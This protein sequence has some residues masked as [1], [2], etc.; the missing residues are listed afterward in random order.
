[1]IK[2]IAVLLVF[3]ITVFEAS[4]H[5]NHAV[6]DGLVLY[7]DSPSGALELDQNSKNKLK[8]KRES[9]NNLSVAP[10]TDLRRLELGL[11]GVSTTKGS[12]KAET[13]SNGQVFAIV[14]DADRGTYAILLPEI[15]AYASHDGFAGH[16]ATP[17]G[18][19]TYYNLPNR[20]VVGAD[21]I[22]IRKATD[23]GDVLL[24]KLE[25]GPD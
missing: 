20:A 12:H 15:R 16:H 10:K 14:K 17:V 5:G 22:E 23:S 1:M 8:R 6:S 25:F 18:D 4:A 2:K 13:F 3:S 7:I 24:K 19:R 9:H 21:W 11:R